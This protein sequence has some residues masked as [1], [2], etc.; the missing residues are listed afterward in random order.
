MVHY[1]KGALAIRLVFSL[2]D[3]I[4]NTKF[5][6]CTL[7]FKIVAVGQ[8]NMHSKHQNDFQSNLSLAKQ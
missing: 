7:V 6:N 3:M 4:T 5:P 2:V 1:R 8:Q